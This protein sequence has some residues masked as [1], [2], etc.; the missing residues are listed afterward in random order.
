MKQSIYKDRQGGTWIYWVDTEEGKHYVSSATAN[1][2]L[3]SGNY[4]LVEL[5]R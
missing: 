5:Q 4:R 2:M 1:R 3:E